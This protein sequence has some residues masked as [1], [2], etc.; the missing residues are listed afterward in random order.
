MMI[1]PP[2]AGHRPAVDVL[3]ED[4][5]QY[6]DFDKI[7]VIMTG[8]GSDGANGLHKLKAKGNVV[9]IAESAKTCIV[10]GMPKA[11]VETNLVNEYRRCR[12][13]WKNDYTILTLKGSY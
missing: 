3:F 4:N 6:N 12:P 1:E 7:V 8:M 10:Y 13:N 9:A 2:R 11:A 5:S